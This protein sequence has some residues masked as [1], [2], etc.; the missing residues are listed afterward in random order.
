MSRAFVRE[1]D[2]VQPPPMLERPVSTA[3]N[4]VTPQ[5]ARLIEQ[6]VVALE[7]QIAAA[8]DDVPALRR[9]LR[10]WS[11]RRATM[12]IVPPVQAP[13]TVEFGVRATIRRKER[14]QEIYIVGE[15]E[16][17]PASGRIAWTAPLSRALRGAKA[18]ETVELKA[19]GRVEAI[20][21]IEIA[22]GELVNDAEPSR[23]L[24]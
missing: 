7:R 5:G 14:T 9:D 24:S 4:L 15:D 2:E 19:A 16:A 1:V 12:Q 8:S 18:G 10:Y 6:T 13:A 11:V 22:A 23:G 17:D 20:T 3:P 21:V